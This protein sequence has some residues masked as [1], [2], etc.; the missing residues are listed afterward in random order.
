MVFGCKCY[1]TAFKNIVMSRVAGELKPRRC[2]CVCR[3]NCCCIHKLY[4]LSILELSLCRDH[5]TSGKPPPVTQK[6]KETL[7]KT[8]IEL[9]SS[10][11]NSIAIL[12]RNHI[13]SSF[14][15]LKPQRY[16]LNTVCRFC[17]KML[18]NKT[19]F[20]NFYDDDKW[21]KLLIDLY[22]DFKK[23]YWKWQCNL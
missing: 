11:L 9:H 18:N 15:G 19:D 12:F 16:W 21:W 22:L 6:V 13:W 1:H 20:K 10:T 7:H 5:F 8:F 2:L 3:L 4:P 17:V 14:G 23:S